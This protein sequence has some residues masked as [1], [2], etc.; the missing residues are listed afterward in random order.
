MKSSFESATQPTV[1]GSFSSV[2]LPAHI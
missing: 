1:P 2:R